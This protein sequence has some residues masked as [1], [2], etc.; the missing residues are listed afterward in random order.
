MPH[1]ERVFLPHRERILRHR[2][3]FRA[4]AKGEA[5]AIDIDGTGVLPLYPEPFSLLGGRGARVKPLPHR[6]NFAPSR[7]NLTPP[8]AKHR[9]IARKQ[10][11]PM[12]MM[13]QR[14]VK[15]RWYRGFTPTRNRSAFL[16]A[17]GQG[18]TLAPSREIFATVSETPRHRQKTAV[19]DDNDATG[20]RKETMVQGFYPCTPE[21]FSLL[22]GRGARVKPLPHRELFLPHREEF[23]ATASEHRAIARTAGTDGNDATGIRKERW[24]RGSTPVPRNRSTTLGEEGQG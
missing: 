20:V 17:E 23:N 12:A 21:P 11:S 22:G 9:A 8:L 7:E 24:Y 18:K 19:T 6:E 14:F 13:L 10:P 2:E 1:R 3:K 5:G 16:K 4:I 15:K